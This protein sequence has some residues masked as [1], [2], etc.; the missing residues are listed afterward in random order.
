VQVAAKETRI[1]GF[2]P[3]DVS[4]QNSETVTKIEFE[5][6]EETKM[7]NKDSG[8]HIIPRRF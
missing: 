3:A 7:T 2:R 8:R 5:T 1:S 6:N 4:R